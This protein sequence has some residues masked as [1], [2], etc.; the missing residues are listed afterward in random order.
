MFM[1]LWPVTMD[2]NMVFISFY[3]PADMSKEQQE[4]E[5]TPEERQQELRQRT[6][7]IGESHS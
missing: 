1:Y 5:P 4:Q 3:R 2:L 7:E 6:M